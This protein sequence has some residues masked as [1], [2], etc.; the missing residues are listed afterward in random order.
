VRDRLIISI[1]VIAVSL[2]YVH[3]RAF[4]DDQQIIQ[5]TDI[6]E[7][8]GAE[9]KLEEKSKPELDNDAL[10][11]GNVEVSSRDAS[12]KAKEYL[13]QV[14]K[15]LT[16][17]FTFEEEFND[18]VYKKST[19]ETSDII[20]RANLGITYKP[21]FTWAKGHGIITLETKGGPV[22]YAS[23]N[24]G[25]EEEDFFSKIFV[26]YTRRKYYIGM[27]YGFTS[28]RSLGA[29][30]STSS[31]DDTAEYWED[32][33]ML[34]I[35]ADW[36]KIPWEIK[37]TE[38]DTSYDEVYKTSDILTRS[39]SLTQY[40]MVS[41]KTYFL[42]NYMHE[43]NDY[44]NRGSN[45]GGE[46]DIFLL[47]VKGK[48][49]TKINGIVT[50][51]KQ[52]YKPDNDN[53]DKEADAAGIE[54]FYDISERL[55]STLKVTKGILATEYDTEDYV[56]S[57]EIGLSFDYSPPFSPKLTLTAK[58]SFED[59]EY[60]SGRKDK[61]YSAGLEFRHSLRKWLVLVG[62]YEFEKRESNIS[63]Q[64]YK[65]NIFSLKMVTQF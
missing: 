53:Q 13:R 54:L 32:Y 12:G 36:E 52:F 49:S 38:E 7:E 62:E 16:F 23:L 59:E 50:F 30:I 18:N 15:D 26:D 44:P 3:P 8:S 41:P 14:I 1:V 27:G 19:D 61:I 4:A 28:T 43:T 55:K 20:T 37:Y 64:G 6:P 56:T 22:S 58:G 65:N 42:I 57:D 5:D 17:I 40:L 47:G 51:G 33:R 39:I 29:D 46:A 2:I 34:K 63:T 11:K 31:A 48:I 45:T 9:L 35:G 10:K 21:E 60:A 25:D 24:T